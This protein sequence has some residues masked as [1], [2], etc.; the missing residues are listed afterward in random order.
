[1]LSKGGN[2]EYYSK[3][4]PLWRHTS[5]QIPRNSAYSARGDI[6]VERILLYQQQRRIEQVI[7]GQ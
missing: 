3:I 2:Y 6:G 5:Q 1:M 7:A 4:T